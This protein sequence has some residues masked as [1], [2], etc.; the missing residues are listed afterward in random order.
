M[1]PKELLR[2]VVKDPKLTI[3]NTQGNFVSID[4]QPLSDSSEKVILWAFGYI[5]RHYQPDVLGI[6]LEKLL[7]LSKC[8][9]FLQTDS[10][11]ICACSAVHLPIIIFN[12]KLLKPRTAHEKRELAVSLLHELTHLILDG[13]EDRHQYSEYE[14]RHDLAC[15]RALN[16]SA[17]A[18]HW[19]WKRLGIDAIEAPE[20]P[21]EHDERTANSFRRKRLK[22]D[23]FREA[24]SPH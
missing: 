5:A 15:Y 2:F 13:P 4:I 10:S 3:Q 19:A 16:M 24:H 21:K 23:N 22:N 1:I 20:L 8:V 12:R 14:A 9:A 6:P 11:E 17:P 18:T 7:E